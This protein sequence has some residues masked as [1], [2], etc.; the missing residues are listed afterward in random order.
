MFIQLGDRFLN[1]ALVREVTYDGEFT[2]LYYS[3]A[4]HDCL[5][6]PG[7]LRPAIIKAAGVI[8]STVKK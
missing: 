5:K 8:P 6:L 2:R 7:D 4:A 1:I 3:A